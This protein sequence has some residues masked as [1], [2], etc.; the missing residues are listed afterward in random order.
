MPP[1][2]GPEGRATRAAP[3]PRA[4]Q[5]ARS[6]LKAR[7]SRTARS[8]KRRAPRAAPEGPLLPPSSG[9]ITLTLPASTILFA[10]A[11]M[12]STIFNQR[13]TE[14]C[15]HPL[16]NLIVFLLCGAGLGQLQPTAQLKL[17]IMKNP[18]YSRTTNPDASI[19][20]LHAPKKQILEVIPDFAI[21]YQRVIHRYRGKSALTT[22]FLNSLKFDSLPDWTSV[23]LDQTY[24]PLLVELKRPITRHALSIKQYGYALLRYMNLAQTQAYLQAEFLFLSPLYKGQGNV[25]LIAAC[26]HY[27]SYM[28]AIQHSAHRIGRD[29]ESL[30][31]IALDYNIAEE[32]ES[33]LE[34][35]IG[36]PTNDDILNEGSE[37]NSQETCDE[38]HSEDGHLSTAAVGGEGDSRDIDDFHDQSVA[39]NVSTAAAGGEGDSRDIDSDF[40]D[41]YR[42]ARDAST[43]A[44]DGDVQRS[45]YQQL[46]GGGEDRWKYTW[47]GVRR[48]PLGDTEDEDEGRA[49]GEDEEDEEDEEEE[50]DEEAEGQAS[51][52]KRRDSHSSIP[53]SLGSMDIDE[54]R[55]RHDALVNE[56]GK[57]KVYEAGDLNQWMNL[58]RYL[59]AGDVVPL[60]GIPAEGELWHVTRE[61]DLDPEE[62]KLSNIAEPTWSPILQFGTPASMKALN[63]L[64]SELNSFVTYHNNN[65]LVS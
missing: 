39:G 12:Y 5:A 32:E 57:Q 48:A 56:K 19:A 49:D 27:W 29:P 15:C 18:S 34:I 45:G 23:T 42:V 25:F 53:R 35:E 21:L 43:T 65:V 8:P 28:P 36:V 46:P 44:V 54:V 62:L 11:Y 61:Q 10:T 40:G 14:D 9:S 1:K 30:E 63:H 37:G 3:R 22:S 38:R 13:L 16:Y 47:E 2:A 20:T 33:R 41:D 24:I 55:S 31:A 59:V 26:G 52:S 60:D 58:F 7:A 17:W 4:A 51:N 64:S 50:E 6:P